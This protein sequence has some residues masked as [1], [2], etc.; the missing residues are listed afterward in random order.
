MSHRRWL[1]SP[2]GS[3]QTLRLVE[4]GFSAQERNCRRAAKWRANVA[5]SHR[6]LSRNPKIIADVT[7]RGASSR[8]AWPTRRGNLSS[9]HRMRC[10]HASPTEVSEC[11]HSRNRSTA[12][13][14]SDRAEAPLEG[15]HGFVCGARESPRDALGLKSTSKR[16]RWRTSKSESRWALPCA[17]QTVGETCRERSRPRIL[18]WHQASTRIRRVPPG[19]NCPSRADLLSTDLPLDEIEADIPAPLETRASINT[20]AARGCTTGQRGPDL[21]GDR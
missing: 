17:W 10:S 13:D 19:P 9:S 18:G 1:G 16:W 15:A 6:T 20:V 2:E 5:F 11:F 12:S 8:P 21:L 3:D 7:S 4:M 14:H